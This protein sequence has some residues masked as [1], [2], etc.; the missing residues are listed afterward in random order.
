MGAGSG[1]VAVTTPIVPG[2]VE[3][4]HMFGLHHVFAFDWIEDRIVPLGSFNDID[5]AWAAGERWIELR[6]NA[7]ET[8]GEA[9]RF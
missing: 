2:V 6:E 9:V 3:I 1:D 5:H 7:G 4:L 8:G